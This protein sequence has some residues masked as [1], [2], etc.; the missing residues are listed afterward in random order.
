MK[1]LRQPL[2]VALV[3]LLLGLS[4]GLVF[5]WR[6]A[7]LIVAAALAEQGVKPGPRPDKGWDFWTIEIDNLTNE[8]KAEKDKL[9]NETAQLEQ[10][11]AQLA[12]ERQELEKFRAGLEKMRHDISV[13]VTEITAEEQKNLRSL[14]QTYSAL[15]PKAAVAILRE[16]DDATVVKLL[17]L[18]KPDIVS[19]IFDEMARTADGG[20]A[21][22][23]KRAAAIS[24]RLRLF[25]ASKAASP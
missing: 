7:A 4:T 22:M 24:E 17:A 11:V 20:N 21:T 25:K 18:M 12:A 19:P 10:R 16:L 1:L 3:A 15:T 8:L 13:G 23:A 9:R 14:A 5:Y 2:V 6:A